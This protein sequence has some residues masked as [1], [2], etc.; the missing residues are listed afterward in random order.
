[1]SDRITLECP[2]CGGTWEEWEVAA[3]ECDLD[4]QLA[5]PGWRRSHA[6]AT[7]PYCGRTA[8][9]AA[10]AVERELWRA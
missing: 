4:P 1:M 7:C 8:C 10:P 3:L 6:S 2:S 5:D 9:C